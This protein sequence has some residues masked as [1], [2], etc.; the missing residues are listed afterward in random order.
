M[1]IFTHIRVLSVRLVLSFLF[2]S[3]FI[4]SFLFSDLVG[5]SSKSDPF[6][7]QFPLPQFYPTQ[8]L[9]FKF[10][11]TNITGKTF[12]N[13]FKVCSIP[14]NKSYAP[15]PFPHHRELSQVSFFTCW[16]CSD[17]NWVSRMFNGMMDPDLIR[18][19]QEH[20]SRMSP[21]E[22][23]RIQQQVCLLSFSTLPCNCICGFVAL[24]LR[25]RGAM[26]ESGF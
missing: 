15:L 2:N 11:K 22:L 18:I 23:A 1:T 19:A 3:Y 21:A 26:S 25:L 17:S 14:K 8:H 7:F 5:G 10:P 20:M 6:S 12:I 4:L 24:F 16:G 9:L 13:L